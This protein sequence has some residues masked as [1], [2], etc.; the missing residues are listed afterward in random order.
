[1]EIEKLSVLLADL[2]RYPQPTRDCSD[3]MIRHV[4]VQPENLSRHCKKSK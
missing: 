1:M 2:G 4:T 3:Q